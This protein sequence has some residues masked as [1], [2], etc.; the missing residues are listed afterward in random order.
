MVARGN[1]HDDYPRA[2]LI[3]FLRNTGM[4][5]FSTFAVEVSSGEER[6]LA[7]NGYYATSWSPDGN[8][9]L[10][11]FIDENPFRPD[12]L[13]VMDANGGNEKLLT[14]RRRLRPE[15]RANWSPDS[16]NIYFWARDLSI[17]NREPNSA[18]YRVSINK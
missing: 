11:R 7:P 16:Q 14:N 17:E 4:K 13:I 8:R 15:S 10:T 9:I 12:I 6:Q 3:L 1:V 2:D 5:S 18:I